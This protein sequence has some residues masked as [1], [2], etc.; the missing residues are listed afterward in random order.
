[1]HGILV[2]H[3][4]VLIII[5]LIPKN[6]ETK[7]NIKLDKKYKKLLKIFEKWILKNNFDLEK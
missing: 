3:N 1:M 4:K 5:I 6:K 7:I 2:S